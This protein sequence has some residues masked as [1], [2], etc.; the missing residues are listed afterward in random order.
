[1][2]GKDLAFQNLKLRWEIKGALHPVLPLETFF[3]YEEG[4]F[5]A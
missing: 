1:M 3:Q 4:Y 5:L 2:E